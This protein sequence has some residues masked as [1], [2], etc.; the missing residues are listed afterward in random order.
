MVLI[1]P[2]NEYMGFITEQVGDLV[3]LEKILSNFLVMSESQVDETM[4]IY[5][6]HSLKNFSKD[7]ALSPG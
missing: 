2:F 3:V 4:Q 7:F 5:A 6:I 1:Q